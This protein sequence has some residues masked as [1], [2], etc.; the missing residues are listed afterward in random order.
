MGGAGEIVSGLAGIFTKP[1]QKARQEGAKGFVKGLGSG[2]LGAMASPFTAT[3][4]LGTNI[5]TG[6]KNSAIRLGKGKLP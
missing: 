2:L 6:I 3:L 4:R 1:Y 5:S